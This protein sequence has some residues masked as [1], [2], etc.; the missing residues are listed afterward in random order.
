[1]KP[2]P[3]GRPPGGGSCRVAAGR[4]CPLGAGAAEGEPMTEAEW[5]ASAAPGAMLKHWCEHGGAARRKGGRRKLR[6]FACACC[7]RIGHLLP[8]ERD[9][10]MVLVSE[11]F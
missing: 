7:R 11:H 1:M 9:R 4:A 3:A 10:H 8:E 2:R 5:Q 6:L